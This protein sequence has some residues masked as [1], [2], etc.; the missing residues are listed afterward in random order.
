VISA[1]IKKTRPQI[2]SHPP[3]YVDFRFDA[4]RTIMNVA[5]D[6]AWF[7][8]NPRQVEQSNRVFNF[9]E[10]QGLDS[11]VNRYSLEGERASSVERIFNMTTLK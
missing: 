3:D 9:F 1:V 2:E 6:Y 7:G 11:Y 10:Q 5:A 4:W 8:Q